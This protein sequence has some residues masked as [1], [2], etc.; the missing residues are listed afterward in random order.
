MVQITTHGAYHRD[1]VTLEVPAKEDA[2]SVNGFGTIFV[3]CSTDGQRWLERPPS[4][5]QPAAR[6]VESKWAP[7]AY[8]LDR[9]SRIPDCPRPGEAYT[10]IGAADKIH[11]VLLALGGNVGLNTICRNLQWGQLPMA[12]LGSFLAFVRSRS[13][14]FKIVGHKATIGHQISCTRTAKTPQFLEGKWY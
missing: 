7:A 6:F 3:N 5:V 4:S 2:Q 14:L 13:D 8:Y 11:D 10:P 9:E 1:F 12:K